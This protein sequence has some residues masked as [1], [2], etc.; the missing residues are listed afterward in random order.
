MKRI[1]QKL[2]A[3]CCMTACISPLAI[4]QNNL[5]ISNE[6]P[7]SIVMVSID[8]AGDELI[9]V[10]NATALPHVHDPQTPRFVLT[11][12][13]GNFALG[14]GGYVRT[15][16]SYDMGGIVDNVDFIPA[17]IPNHSSV[18]NQFQMDASTA[19]IFLKLVGNSPILGDFIVHTEGNFRGSSNTFKLRNAYIAFSGVTIGYTYGGFMDA[20][21]MPATIDFQGPN[22]GTF[23]RTTQLAY[24][25]SG[26]RNFRF[27]AS[28]EMPEVSG[29]APNSSVE[30]TKQRMPDFTA[31]AQY[32]WNDESH[33]RIGGIIR[34][35]SYTDR[36]SNDSHDRTGF[37]VQ[38]STTFTLGNSM[39]MFGQ[40]TYGKGIGQYINDLGEL[41]VDLVSNPEEKDRMQTLPMIGW[42]AGMQYNL[43]PSLFV[44]GTY[45]M[46][47]LYSENNYEA[48]A[49]DNYRYGQYVAGNI[50]WSA[51]E[52]LQFGAEYLRGWRTDFNASTHTANRINLMAKFSF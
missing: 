34:S 46:A 26:L 20:A 23:Y 28:I 52:N 50:F 32:N 22:G 45:S 30:I 36:A 33:L 51:S 11:D 43:T 35:M 25:Y 2:L 10:M 44:S 39:K 14:I 5:S 9:S 13:E 4:G 15:V 17:L 18:N 3:A 41:D 16:A 38:A 7:N 47:R 48:I 24:T 29:T 6:A 19:N 12:R 31:Y 21:A 8:E 27:N 49:Q 37:G 42:F 1:N 40:F